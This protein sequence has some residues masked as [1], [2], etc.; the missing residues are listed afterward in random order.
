[1]DDLQTT[2][3]R[4]D[5]PNAVT[6]VTDTLEQAGHSAYL[7]GGCVRD[8]LCNKTPNDWDITTDATPEE[9][10]A[11]FSHAHYENDFGTVRVVN[12]TVDDPTLDVVEVTTFRTEAAYSD[13]RRPD[14]V[15]FSDSI[16]ADLKRRDFTIN[17]LALRVPH[18][19]NVADAD[20]EFHVKE[21][22]VDL[23]D[24][25]DDLK[26]HTIRTVGD[27]HERFREDGLRMLRAVRFA[28]E[29]RFT[30]N[31]STKSG[32]RAESQRL[33]NIAVERITEEFIK[34]ITSTSPQKGLYLSYNLDILQHFLPELVN[35]YGVEQNQAHDFDVFEHLVRACQ[36][37]A[38]KD[39]PLHI[40]LAALFHDIAKP[41][42][43]R[44][45]EESQ[46]YTFYGHEVVGERVTKNILQRMKFSNDLIESVTNLVRWHMFFSDPDEITL[47]AVRRVIRNVGK[48]N[49][50]D[51]IKLRRADR[52]GMGRP[53]ERPYRLRKYESMI[54]EVLHDPVS[55]DNLAIDGNAVMQIADISPGP[56]VGHILHA[57]LEEIIEDPDKNTKDYLKKRTQ[58]LAQMPD[59]TLQ[60][61]GESGR[62]KREKK[63]QE[64]I[65]QIRNDY[66]V[67]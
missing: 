65:E 27:P 67:E 16:E 57:L 54:E 59:K 53:K 33:A 32:I 44:W 47:S 24:G 39:W 46:D 12:D 45:D 35:T 51:L 63:E 64:A 56:A 26:A 49:I 62:K 29:L 23:F 34:I 4:S 5:I 11:L 37:A 10:L 3:T 19:K 41:Q 6:D 52:V 18:E 31:E 66:W 22:V 17:A 20:D 1:M 8:L 25:L 50:W 48:E 2:F 36:T 13:D 60:N 42:S 30:I 15:E 7:V 9:M 61:L 38:D 28:A 55:V 21:Q 58:D 14:T 43:R 40:R